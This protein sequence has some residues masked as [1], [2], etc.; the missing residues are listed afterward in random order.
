[1]YISPCDFGGICRLCQCSPGWAGMWNKFHT[2]VMKRGEYG[3]TVI[4]N[5]NIPRPRN[6]ARQ[7]AVTIRDS[8]LQQFCAEVTKLPS[9]LQALCL[10]LFTAIPF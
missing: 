2:G 4:T 10:F 3:L 7:E 9:S 1:M 8:I 6:G 5:M